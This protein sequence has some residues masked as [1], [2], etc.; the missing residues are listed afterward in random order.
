MKKIII[1]LAAVATLGAMTSVQA[2]E[3]C[4]TKAS[5]IEKEIRIAKQFGN[6]YKVAGLEKALAEV[7]A[8]CT[9]SSVL[10]DAK[11]DVTKLEKKLAEK[12]EDVAEVQAD[13]R[14]AQAKGDAKKIAK[15]KSKLAEKQADVREIQQELNQARAELAA[16]S[17]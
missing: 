3:S 1:A 11:K 16:L 14:E 15:Y 9:N 8:H 6:T 13:L 4:A 10:A 17:K 12:R 7:K 2:A 5:A